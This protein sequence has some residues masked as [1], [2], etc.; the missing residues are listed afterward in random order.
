MTTTALPIADLRRIQARLHLRSARLAE[1]LCRLEQCR[2]AEFAAGQAEPSARMQLALARR[3]QR[4]DLQVASLRHEQ[5]LLDR[6]EQLLGQLVYA[7][8]MSDR[9]ESLRVDWSTLLSGEPVQQPDSTTPGFF[10]LTSGSLLVRIE[11]VLR[12]LLSSIPAGPVT[13]GAAGDGEVALAVHVPDGDGL[14]LADGR[15]VRY[16]G[17]DAPEMHTWDGGR[18]PFALEARELNRALV[19]GKRVRLVRDVSET[20]RYGRLLRFVYVGE[21]C[22]NAEI[23]RAGL[24]RVLTIRPDST[25]R[26]E[27]ERLEAEARRQKRGL[28][29]Q[30]SKHFS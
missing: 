4:L 28:W 22:I 26:S 19:E 30:P 21:T 24:A 9:L 16:I 5:D 27:Y 8:E 29:K 20:D 7:Q 14:N 6:Q 15:R 17:I 12:E 25:R 10:G 13:Q 18:E 1:D 3:V 11:Q 2:A 23:L